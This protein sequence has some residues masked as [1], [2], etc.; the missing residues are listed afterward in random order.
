VAFDHTNLAT[1]AIQATD[2]VP[3][4]KWEG[5]ESILEFKKKYGRPMRISHWGIGKVANARTKLVLWLKANGIDPEKDVEIIGAAI[6]ETEQGTMFEHAK[7]F[8]EKKVDAMEVIPVAEDLARL[9]GMAAPVAWIS[10]E[11]ANSRGLKTSPCCAAL[12]HGDF[13]K[14]HPDLI[15]KLLRVHLRVNNFAFEDPVEFLSVWVKNLPEV[16]H[17]P[18]VYGRAL[19]L[20]D[21]LAR[22]RRF[23]FGKLYLLPRFKEIM[24]ANPHEVRDGVMEF[25]KFLREEKVLSRDLKEEDIFDYTFF[26]KVSGEIPEKRTMVRISPVGEFFMNHWYSPIIQK[27]FARQAVKLKK[28]EEAK[29]K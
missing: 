13:L 17:G 4:F 21:R 7:L 24:I 10:R 5:P 18:G 9:R 11:W 22:E 28:R 6:I 29:A 15:E 25:V 12:V 23:T 27:E 16:W 20:L 1:L 3:D 19:P 26:D 14:K 8:R 2:G